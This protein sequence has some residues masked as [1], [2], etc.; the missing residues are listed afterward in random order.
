MNICVPGPSKRCKKWFRYMV[1]RSS[2][3]E[4]CNCCGQ[5]ANSVCDCS[6]CSSHKCC[7]RSWALHSDWLED[8]R[9]ERVRFHHKFTVQLHLPFVLRHR[10]AVGDTLNNLLYLGGW[11][12]PAEKALQACPDFA[13]D[14]WPKTNSPQILV[15]GEDLTCHCMTLQLSFVLL[16]RKD[17]P[18][19]LFQSHHPFGF[20]WHPLEGAYLLGKT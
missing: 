19:S 12:A 7:I 15:H 3:W 5:S 9:Q 11:C 1:E 10:R 18:L 13:D 16:Q 17:F 2:R 20:S 14:W 4:P 8:L 6:L